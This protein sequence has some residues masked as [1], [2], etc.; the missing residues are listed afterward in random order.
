MLEFAELANQ[1]GIPPSVLTVLTGTGGALG[2][3]LVTHSAV[4]KVDVTV[5][6]VRGQQNC[7]DAGDPGWY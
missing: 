5:R 7:I 1:A 2:E 6:F 3:T 4:K